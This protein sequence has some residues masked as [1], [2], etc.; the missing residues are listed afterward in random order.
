MKPACN[1]ATVVTGSLGRAEPFIRGTAD[2][3]GRGERARQLRNDRA[4]RHREALRKGEASLSVRV[5]YY[6]FVLALIENG[7]DENKALDRRNV[8]AEAAAII[9]EWVRQ[10]T[11]KK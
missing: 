2:E 4:R 5:N 3:T 8:E 7:L 9:E 10:W 1:D 6:A 11:A